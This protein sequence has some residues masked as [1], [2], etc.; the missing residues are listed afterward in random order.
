MHPSEVIL[1]PVVSEKSTNLRELE[2]KYVFQVKRQASKE[3]VKKAIE[4]LYPVKVTSVNTIVM[5]GKEKRRGVHTYLRS[6]FK[7]AIVALKDGAK[8]P[9]FEDQ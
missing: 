1:R 9:L 2:G 8:L 5:R 7:K 6:N 3:D 4:W